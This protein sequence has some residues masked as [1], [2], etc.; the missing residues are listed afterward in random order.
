MKTLAA[1]RAQDEP[2]YNANMTALVMPLR[3]KL[4]GGSER[5]LWTLLGAVGFLLLIACANVANLLLARAA[6]RE[7]EMAVR[8]ALGASPR[9]LAR[10]LLTESLCSPRV[11]PRVIGLVARGQGTKAL[12]ALVP[13]DLSYQMLADVSVDWRLLAFTAV[14]ALGSG[15]L[16]GLAPALHAG[17]RRRARVAQGRR[18]RRNGASRASGRMRNALVV[19]EMSL[20]LVLLAGRGSHGAQ[21]RRAAAGEPRIRAGACAD[22]PRLSPGTSRTAATPPSSH[23][24]SRPRRRLPRSP[25]CRRWARSAI[26]R[27]PASAPCSGFNVEGR[28]PAGAA[29]KEPGGDMRAVTPGYFRAMGIPLKDGRVFTSADRDGSPTWRW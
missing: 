15:I 4:V 28:P 29:G 2:K 18:P 5:V 26:C 13:S 24:S 10:Q 8:V 22:G 12:V 11:R 21:L 6:S 25:A 19:A 16:F 1:R 9:R 23:S 27:S 3:E 20:A 14:V 7:R 17:A